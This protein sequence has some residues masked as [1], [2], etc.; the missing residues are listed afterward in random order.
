MK[1]AI[2][3]ANLGN[4]DTPILHDVQRW[5]NGVHEI[6]NHIFND[7]NFPPITGL[8]PRLQYRIPKMF[9][10]EMFPDYDIY[11]W[12]DASMKL[13]HKDTISWLLLQLGNADM[14]FFKHPWRKTIKEET[15]HVEEKLRE[16]NRYI[17][18][19]YKNGLHK[20]Q[21]ADAVRHKGF[22]DDRLYAST[23]FIYQDTQAVREFFNIWWFYQSRYY[24]VDQISLPFALYKSSVKVNI[25]NE[26][27][28]NNPYI[29]I[30]SKHK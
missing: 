26:D 4:F 30:G 9:G 13:I 18:P 12:L 24:T 15:D 27:I 14:A 25:I 11:I 5:P 6:V 2:L 16:G 1:I 28:F 10:W 7:D 22:I 8:T 3:T 17:A 21:Y 19:R 23:A 29:A 20:E